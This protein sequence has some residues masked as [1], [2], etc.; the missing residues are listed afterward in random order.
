MT[1]KHTPLAATLRPFCL[2][3]GVISLPSRRASQEERPRIRR[4]IRLRVRRV[5]L[6]FDDPASPPGEASLGDT[7]LTSG[8][9]SLKAAALRVR[10]K[11]VNMCGPE[12]TSKDEVCQPREL[13]RQHRLE[14]A[15]EGKHSA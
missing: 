15:E 4:A 2:R 8:L 9:V 6:A 1:V 5:S 7:D 3:G 10:M 14:A 11:V 12:V 13:H